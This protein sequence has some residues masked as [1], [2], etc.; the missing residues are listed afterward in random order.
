[1]VQNT[2]PYWSMRLNFVWDHSL[3]KREGEEF[4]SYCRIRRIFLLFRQ[5]FLPVQGPIWI[6]VAHFILLSAKTLNLVKC[7][8]YCLVMIWIFSRWQSSKIPN[9]K[10]FADNYKLWYDCWQCRCFQFNPFP[11]KPWFLRVCST[12]LLKTFWELSAIFIKFEIVVCKHFQFR[13]V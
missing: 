13:I 5:C 9:W 10:Y 4:R 11:K 12:S 6:Y 1:M 3:N 8:S 2:S 7:T